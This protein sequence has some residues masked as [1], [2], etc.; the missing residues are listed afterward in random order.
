MSTARYR[1]ETCGPVYG[2]EPAHGAH[3]IEKIR[4]GGERDGEV[5]YY[6][7]GPARETLEAAPDPREE[8]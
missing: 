5:T 8:T 3:V 1:C 4:H 7:V 2:I 6:A